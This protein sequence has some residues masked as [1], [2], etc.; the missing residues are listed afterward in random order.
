[1]PA[2]LKDIAARALAGLD[3]R[4]LPPRAFAKPPA[5]VEGRTDIVEE[6]PTI[7]RPG[8]FFKK[9]VR[10][11]EE[12]SYAAGAVRSL[13]TSFL[14]SR[15]PGSLYDVIVDQGKLAAG[16]PYVNLV[17]VAPR[18]FSLTIGA[19]AA[20]DVAPA[21]LLAAIAAYVEQLSPSGIPAETLTRLKTR[22]V[23]GRA[24]ADKDRRQVYNRL[25]NWLA[26]RNR[27]ERLAEV[28]QR[29]AAVS[30][31]QVAIVLKGLSGSGRVVTGTLI[32]AT[33]RR[34]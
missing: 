2:T 10:I 20:P 26:G 4:A 1:M 9:L 18:T 27:H 31:E 32:P 5:I 23:E 3:P 33:D 30:P 7:Q 24:A 17:R 15:L 34:Q 25:V 11:E 28:P 12:D 16:T 22:A 19:D 6:D 14:T 21:T 29:L 8:A 13:V